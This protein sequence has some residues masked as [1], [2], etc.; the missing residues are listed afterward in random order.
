MKYFDTVTG[1]IFTP[2]HKKVLLVKKRFSKMIM[3][4]GGHVEAKESFI[5]A[6]FRELKEETGINIDQLNRVKFKKPDFDNYSFEILEAQH[7][8]DFIIVEKINSNKYYNDH[9]YCF[10]ID[11]SDLHKK[12]SIEISKVFWGDINK[13]DSY[14][15]YSNVKKTILYYYSKLGSS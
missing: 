3:A 4:P 13:I 12:S 1:Y 2:E 10:V 14:K 7:D 11:E 15:M 8:E 9:I 5:N 6:L